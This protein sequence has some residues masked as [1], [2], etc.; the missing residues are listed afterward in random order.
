MSD[1]AGQRIR[2]DRT[3]AR[4][5]LCAVATAVNADDR[6]VLN[7]GTRTG[8]DRSGAAQGV[9]LTRRIAVQPMTAKH[10]HDMLSRLIAEAAAK[11]NP[12]A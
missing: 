11:T 3:A 8:E 4:S 12:E 10:L 7:F 5:N 2:W 9:S 6:I 1:T